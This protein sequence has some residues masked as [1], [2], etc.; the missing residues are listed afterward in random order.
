[1]DFPL[2]SALVEALRQ[3]DRTIWGKGLNILYESMSNDFI[4]ANPN[5]LLVFGDNHDM[6]RIYTQLGNDLALTKMAMT[7][8]FTIRGIP[9]VY[10]GTEVL[11]NNTSHPGDH[12]SI[13]ADMPGGWASD[14]TN[15]FKAKS[16]TEDQANMQAYVKKLLNWRKGS[17]AVT[18]GKTLHFAPFNDIYVYFRYTDSEKIMVV[19]NR[20]EKSVIVD[21]KRFAE[22]IGKHATAVDI[23]STA[24]FDITSLFEVP[25]KT[26]LVLEIK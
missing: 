8:L 2:Q 11:L 9:Q 12:G 1:M 15:A 24:M 23:F 20:N 17:K 26:T 6:D 5:K 3:K 10:Y 14:N 13:R 18:S 7:Y 19:M 21:P 22:I 25:P 4:Y 16:L